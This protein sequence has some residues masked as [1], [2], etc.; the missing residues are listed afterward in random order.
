MATAVFPK[1]VGEKFS[2]G[3]DFAGNLPEGT[4]ISSAAASAVVV[5]TAE[6]A[7]DD[8]LVS[9]TATVSSTEVNVRLKET[10]AAGRYRVKLTLTLDNGDLLIEDFIVTCSTV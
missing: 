9:T 8:L 3:L 1:R 5:N 6:D 2:C 10:A 4:A 7:S